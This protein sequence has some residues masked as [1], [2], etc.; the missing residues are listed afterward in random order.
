[1][2]GA[3][4]WLASDSYRGQKPAGGGAFPSVTEKQAGVAGG[5]EITDKNVFPCEASGN[6]LRTV[7]FAE[8]QADIFGRRLVAR[9]HHVEPLQGIG[10]VASAEFIEPLFGAGELRSELGDEFGANLVATAA[11][12]WAESRENILGAGA[13]V[14]A[15]L[16]E[17]FFRNASERPA[18]AGMNRGDGALLWID[19]QNRNA[20]GRLHAEQQAGRVGERSIASAGPVRRRLNESHDGR[21]EL[22]ERN[23]PRLRCAE[24][25]LESLAILDHHFAMIPIRETEIQNA[26]TGFQGACAAGSRAETVDEPGEFPEQ[27]EFENLQAANGAQRPGRFDFRRR[28]T[29]GSGFAGKTAKV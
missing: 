15:H 24:S 19:Q 23:Q 22:A 27:R 3:A 6:K 28:G 11:N 1:M 20:I 12:R 26:F 8:V 2:R 21:M 16:A 14:H 4:R 18:P 9:G 13:E 29:P 5:A 10:F 7:G 17:S 25:R